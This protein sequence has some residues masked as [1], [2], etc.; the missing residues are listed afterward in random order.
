MSSSTSAVGK[1]WTGR[2]LITALALLLLFLEVPALANAQQSKAAVAQALSGGSVRTWHLG[3]KDTYMSGPCANDARYTFS[4]SHAGVEDA[5]IGGTIR[6]QPFT[7]KVLDPQNGENIV[8]IGTVLFEVRF[9]TDD[10]TLFARFRRIVP[11]GTEID[12][13]ELRFNPEPQK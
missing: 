4:S 13:F 6:H 3:K 11:Q 8:S 7:W 10:D 2:G 12:E 5:C 9:R 1:R